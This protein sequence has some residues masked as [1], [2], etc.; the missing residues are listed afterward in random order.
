MEIWKDVVGYEGLY[1]VSS[2]GRVRSVEHVDFLGRR[3]KEKIRRVTLNKNGYAYV[4]LRKDNLIK[5]KLV[6]R[7]VAEAFLPNPKNLE[8][9]NHKN[10]VKTDNRVVNLEWM[11]IGD[12]LRYGT[13]VERA[14]KNKPD[15]S[16]PRH[17][18]YGRRGAAAHTHKGKVTAIS[19]SDPTVILE[20]D[21][22]ATAA[23]ALGIYSGA[24]NSAISGKYKTSHG[25]YWRREDG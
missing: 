7:I 13:H 14:T 4:N 9:V 18:N 19:V 16:G 10:E 12:N 23:R 3:Q 2:E 15:M 20:F 22:A 8:T 11:T 24:I 21:T 6:H 5:N 1:Q 17:H 25:Y